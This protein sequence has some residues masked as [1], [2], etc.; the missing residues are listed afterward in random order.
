M[1]ARPEENGAWA[2]TEEN[3]T[4]RPEQESIVLATFKNG[5]LMVRC[6][7]EEAR[8][9][10]EIAAESAEATWDGSLAEFLSDLDSGS[11]F[12]WVR[13]ALGEPSSTD[14]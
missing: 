5:L 14:Q 8:H 12:D 10:V 6:K 13:T 3:V 7:N 2:M 11:K 9:M 4:A 1:Q